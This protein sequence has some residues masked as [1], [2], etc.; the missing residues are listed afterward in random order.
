M[1]NQT[2]NALLKEKHNRMSEIASM[3]GSPRCLSV[4]DEQNN[5]YPDSIKSHTLILYIRKAS[6]D[7]LCIMT[8][9]S[10]SQHHCC[11]VEFE[12]S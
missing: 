7:G 3:V 6:I 11:S 2:K 9:Q 8:S 5:V 12:V 1:D 4:D 10:E